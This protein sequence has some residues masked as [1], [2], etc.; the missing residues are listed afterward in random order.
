MG[1]QPQLGLDEE[2]QAATQPSV[3]LEETQTSLYT[4]DSELGISLMVVSP[5]NIHCGI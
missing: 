2:W 3:T 1:K 4:I 5:I